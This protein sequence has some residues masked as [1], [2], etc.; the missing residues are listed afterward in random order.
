MIA[1]VFPGQGSQYI[2]MGQNF[3]KEFS[4]ARQVFEEANDILHIDLSHLIFEGDIETLTQTENV[5]PALLTVSLA[6][7]S[8]LKKEYGPF[9]FSIQMA[10]HSLGE[11]TALCAAGALKWSDGMR[12]VRYR[13]QVMQEAV[14]LGKGAMAAIL[15]LS[16][17]DVESIVK[18]FSSSLDTL[19]T[20]VV[21]NDNCPGQ[22]VIS[23]DKASVEGCL[24][25]AQHKGA[26]R[27]ISLPVSAPFHSPLM[28][29][30]AKKMKD[31]LSEIPISSLYYPVI[32]NTRAKPFIQDEIKDILV[33]QMVGRVRWRETIQYFQNKGI[34]HSVEIGAGKILTGLNSRITQNITSFSLQNPED[35]KQFEKLLLK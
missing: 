31:A 34:T 13:G 32:S 28:E 21:A 14:P 26:R 17:E 12:L 9:P 1:F 5:Q 22:V 23:G 30:A 35:L 11:Y 24:E 19:H 7:F 6:L 18:P 16:L 20:C 2:G 3:F 29:P 27:V 10:G 25:M 4:A 15:G 8:V 33:E